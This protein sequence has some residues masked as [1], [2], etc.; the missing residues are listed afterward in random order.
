MQIL[1]LASD[2]NEIILESKF[3]HYEKDYFTGDLDHLFIHQRL[4]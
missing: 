4:S 1:R 3:Y 2:S